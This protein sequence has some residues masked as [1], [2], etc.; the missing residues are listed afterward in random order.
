ME[1]FKLFFNDVYDSKGLAGLFSFCFLL[2]IIFLLVPFAFQLVEREILTKAGDTPGDFI[3]PSRDRRKSLGLPGAAIT[4]FG[5]RRIKSP[6]LGMSGM[7]N[8][9]RFL[10]NVIKFTEIGE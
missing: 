4:I 2:F 3:R 8:S 9:I 1:L 5:D 7:S 6:I 10:S